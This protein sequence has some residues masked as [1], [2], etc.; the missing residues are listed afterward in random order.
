MSNARLRID[1]EKIVLNTSK[2]MA[3][4]HAHGFEIMGVTKG[5]AG[6]PE[7]VKAMVAG[8]VKALGDSRLE[9]IERFRKA[10][11]NT[12]TTL[13]RTPGPSDIRRTIELADASLNADLNVVAALSEEA[14]AQHKIHD[15]ILMA[16]LDAGR[17][18]LAA[19]QL[20]A[21][22]READSLAGIRLA[23]IGS[24]FHLASGSDLHAMALNRL[25]ES[26][27][28]IEIERGKPL[29]TISGGSSNIFR[30][31]VLEGRRNPGVNHLRIGT[32]ILLGFSSSLNPVTISGFE[33]DTFVL[34][35]EVIEVKKHRPGDAILAVGKVDT[36]PHF[37]FPMAPG[38]KLKEATSD[39]LVASIEPCPR[40]GD[41]IAFRLGYPALC[42]LMVSPYVQVEH[43]NASGFC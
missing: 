2:T 26:A 29:E 5:V 8:G 32:A 14:C 41:W 11:I 34:S 22:C 27:R 7:V 6:L 31:I 10:G 9:N 12:H 17:E 19:D 3:L 37:L 24:Y 13:L 40:V 4:G 38:F 1:L 28:R 20:P 16:D 42:R 18:G 30:T 35:V 15:V 43:V 25:V 23:G 39:H 36:D 33:R 21:A